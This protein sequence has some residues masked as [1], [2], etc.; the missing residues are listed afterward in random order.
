[1]NIRKKCF[2]CSG[3]RILGLSMLL[4][5]AALFV[6]APNASAVSITRNFTGGAAPGNAAGTGNLVNIF[7]AAADVWEL[8]LPDPHAVTINFSWAPLAVSLGVHNL[9]TQGGV[10]NRE[11]SAQIRFDNDG[12]S[13][14][15]LDAT[16]TVNE[17]YST[18]TASAQNLGGGNINTGRIFTGASGNAVSRFDLFTIALHEIAHALGLSGLNTSFQAENVDLDIDVM[19]PRPFPGTVIP[20]RNGAHLAIGTALMFP[21]ANP[22]GRRLLPSAVDILANCQISQFQNCNLN[23]VAAVPTPSTLLL[24]GV[25]LL[26]FW[27]LRRRKQEV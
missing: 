12:S 6:S 26:G 11:T 5:V 9:L 2:P 13:L 20:T 16:P 10:P 21:F 18:F 17:E 22:P 7:N 27:G 4:V 19:G 24:L 23:L 8:A 15:F 14:W 3:P 25:G 1:M